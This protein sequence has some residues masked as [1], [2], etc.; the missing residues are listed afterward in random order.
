MSAGRAIRRSAPSGLG[1]AL[2]LGLARSA[3][4]AAGGDGGG[5]PFGWQLVNLLILLG[6]IVYFARRPIQEYFSERRCG[7][8][9]EIE[10]ANR[11]LGDAERRHAELQ[12]RL[13]DLDREVEGIRRVARERGEEEGRRVL[14]D[15]ERAAE[16]I[17]EDARDAIEQ[18]VRRARAALRREAADLSVELAAD[19][20]RRHVSG[21]DQ[22]RLVDEF[23]E[24]IESEAPAARGGAR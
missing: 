18:E 12:R 14:A 17:R 2:G 6:V 10:T 7:I 3:A 19:L 16:R 13:G 24:R 4:A 9:S 23:I 15:A 8:E 22:G 20:I 21:D 5:S 11:L 1:L